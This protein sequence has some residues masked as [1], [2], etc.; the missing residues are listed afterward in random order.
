MGR[1]CRKSALIEY[2]KAVV[3]WLSQ[4]EGLERAASAPRGEGMQ[5]HIGD[6]KISRTVQVRAPSLRATNLPATYLRAA[7]CAALA[8]VVVCANTPAARAGDDDDGD[9]IGSKI[10][11]TLGLKS[12]T[13][14]EYGIQYTE[15]P[16]LVVPPTRDLP[17]PVAA[18]SPPS[19]NWP[20]DPDIK[21]RAEAKAKAKPRPHVDWVIDSDRALRPDELNKGVPANS[22]GANTAGASGANGNNQQGNAPDANAKKSIFSF[23]WFKK[24]E[25]ATFTGEPARTTLTDPP[26]GYLTPSPDQPYGI[27]PEKKNQYKIPTLTD[28]VEA[29]R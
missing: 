10:M 6:R 19:P 13:D 24:E 26:P 2:I 27:A 16:P 21:K 18:A 23:N 9:S 28:R 15:R 4:A 20:K 1:G 3:G 22:N 11:R 17:P 29:P 12:P 25:Y 8:A 14:T 5:D 7:L